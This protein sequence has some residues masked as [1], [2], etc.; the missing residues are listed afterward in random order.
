MRVVLPLASLLLSVCCMSGAGNSTVTGLEIP[1]VDGSANL[2]SHIGYTSCYNEEYL[3]PDWIAWEL[4]AEELEGR[5]DT[6]RNYSEDPD[7]DGSQAMNRDYVNSGY[8]HGHMAPVGDM[9]WSSQAIEESNYLTNMCPQTAELNAG[10]WENVE[11][12]CRRM[13][14]RYGRVWITCGPL[15]ASSSPERIGRN[16]VVVPDAFFK[17]VLVKIRDDYHGI[18]FLFRNDDSEQPM[19]ECAVRVDDVENITGLDFFPGLEDSVENRVESEFD[20]NIWK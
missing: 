19:R 9:K 7:W 20:L 13:A 2:I 6:Y 17:V 4:T 8:T 1:A 14:R 12:L 10:D 5:L 3:I 15:V 11:S 16:G 18:G